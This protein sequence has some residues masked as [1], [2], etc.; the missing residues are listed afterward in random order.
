[1]HTT[2]RVASKN[3]FI[4]GGSA[5]RTFIVAFI[6]A[7]VLA[8]VSV[9]ALAQTP[10]E[11]LSQSDDFWS[12]RHVSGNGQRSIDAAEAALKSG[13][14]EFE[15]RWRIARGAFWVAEQ[16]TLKKQKERVGLIGWENGQA[17]A[18]LKPQRVECYFWGVVSLGQYAKGIGVLRAIGKGVRSKFENFANK[19][20]ALDPGYELAGPDRALAVYWRDLP[21]IVRDLGKAEKHINASIARFPLK[22]RSHLYL[23]EIFLM[24]DRRDKARA[25]LE[26]CSKMDPAAEDYADGVVFKR[27][28]A[29]LLRREFPAAQGQ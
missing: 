17:C 28:C 23:A 2:G 12:K 14:D 18:K 24:S 16:T 13:A 9:P 10:D 27:Q 20:L 22:I 11:L 21:A 26:K 5:M 29:E 4:T 1:M 25:E 15:A 19:A 8:T 6:S 3:L 7:L